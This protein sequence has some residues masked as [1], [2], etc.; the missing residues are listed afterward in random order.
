[1][2]ENIIPLFPQAVYKVNL[3]NIFD[4]E[5]SFMKSLPMQCDSD[6]YNISPDM[7]KNVRVLDLPQLA[8]MKNLLAK[9]SD[10]FMKNILA[11]KGDAQLTQSWLNKNRPGEFT[12]RHLHSN[13][14]VSGV[15]Y[16]DI[17]TE[18][19]I[20]FHSNKKMFGGYVLEY[21]RDA[22]LASN[23]IF[24]HDEITIK[25]ATYDL[26]LFE[27]SLVHSVPPNMSG[28]DRWSLAFN[29]ITK[30]EIGSSEGL[31]SI[32]VL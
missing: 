26:V 21:A 27:S 5:I 32:K 29:C 30:G 25:V 1:M 13:S 6:P 10:S 7:S 2:I 20:V 14:F 19:Q 15:F 4:D 12:P 8:R 3:G 31:N 24:G 16:I 28:I 17:P 22:Q 9:Y 11:I 23:T 18:S